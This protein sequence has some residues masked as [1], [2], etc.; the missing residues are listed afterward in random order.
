MLL[1]FAAFAYPTF[2]RVCPHLAL[3]MHFYTYKKKSPST[4][5]LLS[6]MADMILS[7]CDYGCLYIY[8]NPKVL[9]T[10]HA[11]VHFLVCVCV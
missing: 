11:Y 8:I 3:L 6:I 5:I 1:P 9:N 10:Q 2:T 7:S 4:E